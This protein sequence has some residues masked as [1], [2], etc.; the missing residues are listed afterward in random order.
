[1]K[2]R[3]FYR[4]DRMTYRNLAGEKID[5]GKGPSGTK[6]MSRS[7]ANFP[8]TAWS[9]L[10]SAKERESGAYLTAMN[11]CIA[12][13]WKPVFYFIRSRGYSFDRA[14]DLTQEFFLRFFERDW[15]DRADPD[16]GR[17]R[18]L[19][20][21]MLTRFLAD[22][23]PGR[24]AKQKEFDRR[25]VAVSTLA[26]ESERSFEPPDNETPDLVFMKQWAAAT[27]ANVLRRVQDW[28]Q[29]Q[30]RPDWH[31]IFRLIHF[32]STGEKTATQQAVAKRL[33][34]TRDRVR[35][36]LE[37]TNRQF[38]EFLRAEVAD[39]VVSPDDVE[40]EINEINRLLGGS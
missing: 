18:N 29:D 36:G 20:L 4:A 12:G 33:N 24:A 10:R 25:I 35:Y 34:L 14:E 7:S 8:T 21:T 11:R 2:L 16:R 39:Q 5:R 13:Y 30:G 40:E 27:L 37:E 19:L 32:R 38:V 28:C 6:I 17:F 9:V 15:I 22:Q 1:M 3:A 31:E 26:G 23:G